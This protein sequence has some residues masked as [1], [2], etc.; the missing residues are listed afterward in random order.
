MKRFYKYDNANEVNDY[1]S[2]N[3]GAFLTLIEAKINNNL[4]QTNT[5]Y[6]LCG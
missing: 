6:W 1:K 5:L 2:T 3:P 4:M